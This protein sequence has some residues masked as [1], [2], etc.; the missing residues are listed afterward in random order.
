MSLNVGNCPK[1]GKVYVK[2]LN[3]MCPNCLKGIELEYEKCLKYLRDH[4]SCTIQEMSEETEVSERQIVK[5]IRDGRLTIASNPNIAYACEIC[6][7][8]IRE[9]TICE[10]CRARLAKDASNL[11]ED[12]KRRKELEKLRDQGATFKIQDRLK[13]RHK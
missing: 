11:S 6:S 7:A 2:N 3:G 12:E 1:C 4:R 5:F 13:D 10:P 8:S 9:G